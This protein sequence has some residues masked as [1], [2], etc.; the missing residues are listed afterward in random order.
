MSDGTFWA[1]EA[2]QNLTYVHSDQPRF[3]C[4]AVLTTST[5]VSMYVKPGQHTCMLS[6]FIGEHTYTPT[7]LG[8]NIHTENSY[9]YS[10]F[11]Y[12]CYGQK[13]AFLTNLKKWIGDK[14]LNVF[15]DESDPT[16]SVSMYVQSGQHTCILSAFIGEHT[17]T[18]IN[19]GLNIHT[20]MLTSC[21]SH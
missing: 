3:L 5:S 4:V 13:Y 11:Q 21:P 14:I 20:C 15:R 7:N 16:P 10:V 19:L 9:L 17:Y 6:A 1:Q 2:T 8:P 18:P 12:V